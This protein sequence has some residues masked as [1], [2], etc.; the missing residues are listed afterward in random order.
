MDPPS[1][2]AYVAGITECTTTPGRLPFVVDVS[3]II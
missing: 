3:V 1:S 2:P